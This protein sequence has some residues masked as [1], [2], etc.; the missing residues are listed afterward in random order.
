[1]LGTTSSRK[2]ADGRA[3]QRLSKFAVDLFG[4][5]YDRAEVARIAARIVAS[6]LKSPRLPARAVKRD[7][8]YICSEYVWEC[9]R[10]LG[11]S[12]DYDRRGFIAPADFAKAKGVRLT[13]VI[14]LDR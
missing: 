6:K 9:Y 5:P 14:E 10:S 8:E 13:A 2:K 11:I 1:M 7:R 3:L 4:Y 12:I